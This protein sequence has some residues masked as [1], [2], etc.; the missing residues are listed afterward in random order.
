MQNLWLYLQLI[1]AF[2]YR[3]GIFLCN[4]LIYVAF[5]IGY[6]IIPDVCKFCFCIHYFLNFINVFDIYKVYAAAYVGYFYKDWIH[7]QM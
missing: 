4:D 3:V 5:T 2:Q 6:G 7:A 1:D